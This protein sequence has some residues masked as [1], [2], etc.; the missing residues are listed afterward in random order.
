MNESALATGSVN[1]KHTHTHRPTHKNT[2]TQ[3]HTHTPVGD[4]RNSHHHRW[5]VFGTERKT[6]TRLHN[7]TFKIK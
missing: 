4:S 2:H 1:H 7:Y 3:K 5:F 6:L